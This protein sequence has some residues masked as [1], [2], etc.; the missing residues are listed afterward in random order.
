[1]KLSLVVGMK[2]IEG[3]IVVEHHNAYNW[4]VL[5]SCSGEFVLSNTTGFFYRRFGGFLCGTHVSL[6][7][8]AVL[9]QILGILFCRILLEIIALRIGFLEI[10]WPNSKNK[11]LRRERSEAVQNFLHHL[12]TWVVAS[13]Y[14]VGHSCSTNAHLFC[15]SLCVESLGSHQ[16]QKSLLFVH[17]TSNV[18]N[19]VHKSGAK[20]VKF[21]DI[22]KYL[23]LIFL[24]LFILHI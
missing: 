14:N 11:P 24:I 5:K 9:V 10:H 23:E 16:S 19:F 15:K 12:E 13:V 21:F 8:T 1:M 3:T 18:N 2:L 20:I 4:S 7:E 22:C 17:I 6:I